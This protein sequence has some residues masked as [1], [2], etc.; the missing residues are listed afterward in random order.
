MQA[1][2]DGS[3]TT[4]TVTQSMADNGTALLEGI[5]AEAS[6]GLAAAITLEQAAVDMPSLVGLNMEEA[7]DELVV[8]RPISDLYVTIVLK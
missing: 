1:L 4:I 7:W 8:R 5:K 6:Q 2:D 3:G